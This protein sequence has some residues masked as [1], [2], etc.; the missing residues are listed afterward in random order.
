[1]RRFHIVLAAAALATAATAQAAEIPKYISDAVAD[2]GRPEAD[3][4]RDG[5]RKPAETI[6]FAGVKRG[7]IVAELVPGRGYYTRILSKTV[8][9]KGHVYAITG[10]EILKPIP[11]AADAAQA[12]AKDPAFANVSAIT[13]P[14]AE[15]KVPEYVD[16]VWTTQN[17][18][19]LKIE[20]FFGKPD[21]LKLNK[22]IYDSLKPGGVYFV[23]DHSAENGSGERD[24]ETLH[25]IDVETVKQ[26]VLAAGFVLEA[27]GDALRNPSDPRN[28]GVFDASIRGKT[29]QFMLRFRKPQK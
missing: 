28:I 27:E 11:K 16:V 12:I 2:K 15:L 7:M 10:A 18:H 4:A 29:D 20:K 14:A 19:D 22:S 1:M 26:E 6:Q 8:G 9:P 23:L 25:R 5:D 3:V 13:E 21:L 17:Y 24:V